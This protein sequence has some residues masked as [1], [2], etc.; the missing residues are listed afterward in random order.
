MRTT[1]MN[2]EAAGGR[3]KTPAWVPVVLL[4]MLAGLIALIVR[5]LRNQPDRRPAGREYSSALQRIDQS[6]A[7]LKKKIGI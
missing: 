6:I 3:G 1:Q 7:D 2:V 5:Q 4:L